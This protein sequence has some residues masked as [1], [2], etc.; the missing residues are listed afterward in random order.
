MIAI[1]IIVLFHVKQ[2]RKSMSVVELYCIEEDLE[3]DSTMNILA[4]STSEKEAISYI[5]VL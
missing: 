1:A 2:E 4:S 3:R 5:A